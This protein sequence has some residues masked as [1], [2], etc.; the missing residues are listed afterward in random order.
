MSI[1]SRI[2]KKEKDQLGVDLGTSFLK[3]V[4]LTKK[5]GK[6]KLKNY[7]LAEFVSD[8]LKI[9]EKDLSDI[10]KKTML[11]AKIKTRKANMSIPLFSSFSII[12]EMPFLPEKELAEAIPFEARQ[13]IPVSISDVSLDWTVLSTN[14]A[15]KKLNILLVAV[16]LEVI[17]K[18][19]RLSKLAGLDLKN[20][21]IE[22]FSLLRSIVGEKTKGIYCITDIG[23]RSTNV[24]IIDQ[25]W[26]TISHYYETGGGELSR[27]LQQSLNIDEKRA[28]A[29]KINIGLLGADKEKEISSL[30]LLSADRILAEIQR[31]LNAYYKKYEKRVEKIIL[32]GGT[33]HL[34]GLIEYFNSQL[35]M[36]TVLANSF[37]QVDYPPILKPTIEE[38]N[39]VLSIAVG[40]ALKD[41]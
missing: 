24:V 38:L 39:P 14:E 29:L 15:E 32:H 34:K 36:E 5:G 8:P 7:A 6:F 9:S 1:F 4:E 10:I 13:Y 19:T 3:I 17:N 41:F 27:V 21:E 35:G 40:L 37:S 16:P 22:S 26:P 23:Y 30:L 11:E 25:G 20:L 31:T 28:E 18:Y 12:I 2:F 33:A